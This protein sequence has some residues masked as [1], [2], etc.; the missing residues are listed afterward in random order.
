MELDQTNR[1]KAVIFLSLNSTVHVII[2][3]TRTPSL[4]SGLPS[5]P[6]EHVVIATGKTYL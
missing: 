3:Q 2:I 6:P 5:T 1:Q 4:L